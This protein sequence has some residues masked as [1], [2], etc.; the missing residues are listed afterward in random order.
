MARATKSKE[1]DGT[2]YECTQFPIKKALRIL[3]RL[4]KHLGAPLSALLK[5][6]ESEKGILDQ[7]LAKLDV[8]GAIEA[9]MGRVG[10]DEVYDLFKDICSD[11]IAVGTPN[12][13]GVG[14]LT[15]DTFDQ[16]FKGETG[17]LRLFKVVKFALEANYGNFLS[18]IVSE[19]GA[20]RVRVRS[21]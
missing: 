7:D 18:K 8:G 20:T 11:V 15:D 1:I 4:S 21:T 9:M 6:Y 14:L 12:T 3:T 13:P 10:D 5:E 19:G 17:L 2:K 16:H